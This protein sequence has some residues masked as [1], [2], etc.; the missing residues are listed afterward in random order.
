MLDAIAK[1]GLVKRA[2]M[3]LRMYINTGSVAVTVAGPNTT[4]TYY[5]AFTST[6]SNTCPFTVNL[7]SGL[8]ASGGFGAGVNT[9]TAG[10]Y[11]GKPPA[12]FPWP[13]CRP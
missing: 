9:I 13:S 3:R 8:I 1:I 4:D 7:L 12:S 10:L 6:F 11:I 5:S 2:D